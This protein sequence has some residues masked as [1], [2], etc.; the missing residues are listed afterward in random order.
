MA[1]QPQLTLGPASHLTTELETRKGRGR[2][3]GEDAKQQTETLIGDLQTLQHAVAVYAQANVT[4][5]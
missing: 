3:L 4:G 2:I 5:R 1:V